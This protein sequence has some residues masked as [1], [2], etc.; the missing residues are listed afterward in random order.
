MKL[1]D[2]FV[3]IG[4]DV[5][6]KQLKQ[7]D[8]GLAQTKHLIMAVAGAAVAGA[9]SLFLLAKNVA[10]TGDKVAKTADKLGV[11][12]DLLQE[13]HHVGKLAS[14]TVQEMNGNL[15]Q[16]T[17]RTA[18][19]AKG[20]GEAQKAYSELGISLRDESGRIKSSE[21]LLGEVA[22]RF[23]QM[24]SAQDKVRLAYALFG[25]SGMG[26][27]NVL[28]Q[29]AA[30]LAAQRA[31][32]H[33]LGK[34]LSEQAARD[35]EKFS[36][37]L[38]RA[39]S[40]VEGIKNQVG[41]GLLPV[42]TELLVRFRE[43]VLVNRELIKSGIESFLRGTIA[44]LRWLFNAGRQVVGVLSDMVEMFGGIERVAKAAAWAVALI[45]GAYILTAIGNVA[46]GMVALTT[47]IRLMG[48][49]AL[50]A[51][52]KLLAIPLLIGAAIL[53]AILAFQD[54]YAYVKGEK[55]LYGHLVDKLLADYPRLQK[56]LRVTF[57]DIISWIKE[58]W[59]VLVN[60]MGEK[61]S[62][63]LKP[64]A[65]IKGW[66]GSAGGKITGAW[67]AARDFISSDPVGN[68]I[69]SDPVGKMLRQEVNVNA[70]VTVTVPEGTPP[71]QVGRAVQQGV[72]DGI[73]RMLR[74][75]SAAT[76]P[77]VGW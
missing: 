19:A 65:T 26:M 29:G 46:Q 16:F 64:L 7:L 45:G 41:A 3:S 72:S 47:S 11:Q 39:L 50:I 24:E 76:E 77:A 23:A 25:R 49:A 43:W 73:A 30:G 6:D 38:M 55:S 4:F 62:P 37:A 34:V 13:L 21:R 17:R 36:D 52:A 71:D 33:E 27:I 5:D 32:A 28:N 48:T 44:L 53:V 20:T 12:I 67:N 22:D 2:L 68:F 75:A 14:M 15:E 8:K 54:L 31:E 60:W 57:G 42:I 40:V 10:D 69:A 56:L 59:E 66:A 70:P 1:R 74:D 35:S 61:L 51:Q 63:L 18:D 58:Q 9:G